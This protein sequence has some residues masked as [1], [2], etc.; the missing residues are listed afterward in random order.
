MPLDDVSIK[1]L[2]I[3]ETIPHC[4]LK[5]LEHTCLILKSD[6]EIQKISDQHVSHHIYSSK[7]CIYIT[8]KR[9]VFHRDKLQSLS[10]LIQP[11]DFFSATLLVLLP[12]R[13]IINK[14]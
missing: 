7:R 1:I 11:V 14:E 10:R 12:V 2:F 6:G 5:I 3:T 8:F 9:F 13:I 4:R